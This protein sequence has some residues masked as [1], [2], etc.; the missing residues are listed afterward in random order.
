MAGSL[1]LHANYTNIEVQFTWTRLLNDSQRSKVKSHIPSAL[2][3]KFLDVM[4][5]Y[6]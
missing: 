2:A 1:D 6:L 3:Y 4:V 5:P